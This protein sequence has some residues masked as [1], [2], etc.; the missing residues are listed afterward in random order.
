MATTSQ[1]TAWLD[2]L[3]AE[4][5][6]EIFR[7]L[8]CGERVAVP[9]AKGNNTANALL[10]A[11]V[12]DP[13]KYVEAREVFYRCNIFVLRNRQQLQ[14]LAG[15][16][17]PAFTMRHLAYLELV[18]M[19]GSTDFLDAQSMQSAI[20]KV[21]AYLPKLKSLT[22]ACDRHLYGSQTTREHFKAG[23][24][25]NRSL[26]CTAVGCYTLDCKERFLVQLKHYGLVHCWSRMKR[27]GR[28]SLASVAGRLNYPARVCRRGRN[29][30]YSRFFDS[31]T[32]AEWI[33][34]FDAH[35]V[36]S[37]GS[38]LG[39][40]LALS[41]REQDILTQ[42]RDSLPM[43]GTRGKTAEKVYD[44]VSGG[45]SFRDLDMKSSPE[46]LEMIGEFL[47][48]IAWRFANLLERDPGQRSHR[49]DLLAKAYQ[50]A[51]VRK[52][53]AT[54]ASDDDEMDSEVFR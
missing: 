7:Q 40:S 1:P 20:L 53:K 43:M 47:S 4:I 14:S 3:S 21:S 18:N 48:A 27:S 50:N 2:K 19:R 46:T 8:Y 33:A 41:E 42:F 54:V 9:Q 26:T 52:S 23:S 45:T 49:L 34:V 24:L 17:G 39:A 30:I 6:I 32:L 37:S 28:E 35:V 10:V 36:A 25:K 31:L 16:Q 5:R 22:I 11:L 44:A 12:N 38:N 15:C 13:Q 51:A 29:D